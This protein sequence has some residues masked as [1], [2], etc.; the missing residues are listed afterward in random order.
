VRKERKTQSRQG[1]KRHRR[2][3]FHLSVIASLRSIHPVGGKENA[4]PPRCKAASQG[5][6]SPK[7][8]CVQFNLRKEGK[9]QSRQGA[10]GRR[11]ATFHLSVIASLRS[12][13]CAGGK[14]NAKPPR[15]KAASQGC[16]SSS[17]HRVIAFTSS[18]GRKGKTQSRQGAKG[19]RRTAFHLSGAKAFNGME[20]DMKEPR[21]SILK[22]IH[23][24]FDTI[25]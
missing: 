4:K 13:H 3:T 16:F 25:F 14:E 20:L 22:T 5:C 1:A 12:I 23:N 19:R 11:R 2:A 6:F 17:R 8:H 21:Y 15:R 7:R 9:T 10:K 24:S 18:C